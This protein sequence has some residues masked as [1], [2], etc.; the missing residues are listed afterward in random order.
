MYI[1][2]HENKID[3]KGRLSVPADFRRLLEK[4]DPE[5]EEGKQARMVVVYGDERRDYLEVHSVKDLMDIHRQIQRMD[6][7]SRKR[8]ELQRLY[9]HQVQPVTLDDTGRIVLNATLRNKIGLTDTAIVVGNSDTFLIYKPETY[10][11]AA[12]DH[13]RAEDDLDPNLDPSVYLGGNLDLAE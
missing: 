5:W 8:A 12:L 9:A 3:S 10:E 1:G 13:L 6:R 7:G 11:N 4:N 2:L